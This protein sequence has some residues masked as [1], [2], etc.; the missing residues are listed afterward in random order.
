MSA[1][2][3]QGFLLPIVAPTYRDSE[4]VDKN[5]TL[6]PRSFLPH[7][8]PPK[9]NNNHFIYDDDDDGDGIVMLNKH[10]NAYTVK[11]LADEVTEMVRKKVG[12]KAFYKAHMQ[13]RGRVTE[14]RQ[15]RKRARQVEAIVNPERAAQRRVKRTLKQRE[16]KKQKLAAFKVNRN[17]IKV[18]SKRS[19]P[20]Q[21]E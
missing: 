13:V 18:T 12:Q 6:C 7:T 15:K 8:H 5:S 2:D 21:S 11:D 10:S 9:K 3:L 19:L 4:S 14:L 1:E 17:R 16:N 20:H